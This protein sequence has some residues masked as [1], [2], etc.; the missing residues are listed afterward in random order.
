MSIRFDNRVAIITGAGGGLGKCYAI[1]YA[2]RGAKVIVNDLGT[3]E[4]GNGASAEAA[5]HVVE[6]I[7]ATGGEA[8]ADFHNVADEDGAAKIIGTA[9][10]TYG[11]VDI[12]INNAGIL[13]DRSLGKMTAEDYDLVLKVHL[14]GSFYTSKAAFPHMKEHNYG[15]ILMTTSVAG[16]YGNFGQ[17]NYSS[18][19]LGVVGL[20]N[21]LKEEGKKYNICVNTIAPLA[22]SRMGKGVLPPHILEKIKPEYVA[23]VAIYLCSDRCTESGHIISAGGGYYSGVQIVEGAGYCFD[24][25]DKVTPEMIEEKY[26]EITNMSSPGHYENAMDAVGVILQKS[27]ALPESQ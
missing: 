21:V 8:V 12:V 6:L 24:N 2:R 25:R 7:K 20:M 15:R 3:S 17:A 4:H 1:E 26:A 13:R 23:P 19:K 11:K 27:R 5:Q 18:A 10:D 14:Y 9:L 22:N 16:L